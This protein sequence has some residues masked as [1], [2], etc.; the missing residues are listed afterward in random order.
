M[1]AFFLTYAIYL[2]TGL[3]RSALQAGF[4]IL[5]LSAG[6]LTGSFAS[7]AIG[8]RAG[9]AAP[10]LGFLCSAT[11]LF[12]AA[13]CVG[14]AAGHGAPP[15]FLF[16]AP[17]L[18]VMG[19]GVGLAL[20]TMMR[21][22]VERVAQHRAGLVGGLFNTVLQISA[23]LGRGGAGRAVLRHPWPG[24]GPGGH[25]PRLYRRAGSLSDA[26]TRLEHCSRWAWGSAARHARP[27]ARYPPCP[28]RSS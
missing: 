14:N 27:Q 25:R 10:S 20:P 1:A 6:L 28:Q 4:D 21:V 17:A 3:G 9:P 18:A 7:P 15:S 23:A 2:Q 12:L 11:G 16:L 19:F 5:P 13:Q 24:V 22:V 8:R 26:V